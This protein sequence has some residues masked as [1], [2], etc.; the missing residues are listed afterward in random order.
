MTIAVLPITERN[1]C[2][3]VIKV[4]TLRYG[5]VQAYILFICSRN[6][7]LFLVLLDRSVCSLSPSKMFYDDVRF[8]I[9]VHVLRYLMKIR[10]IILYNVN[11]FERKLL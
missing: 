3:E 2:I 4:P 6:L 11:C 1:K 9:F 8:F 7:S 10:Y 5:T